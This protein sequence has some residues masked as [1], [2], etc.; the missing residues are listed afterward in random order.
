MSSV[1]G[2]AD[3]YIAQM[4]SRL[5]LRV[6]R[7]PFKIRLLRGMDLPLQ[8]T[9]AILHCTQYGS[10]DWLNYTNILGAYLKKLAWL[11]VLSRIS[12]AGDLFR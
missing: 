12:I 1:R 7:L 11:T 2:A 10:G 3:E 6:H 8:V 5:R 4:Q 9:S